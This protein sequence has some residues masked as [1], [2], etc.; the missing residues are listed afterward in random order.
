MNQ[1]RESAKI[2]INVPV[3]VYKLLRV[4]SIMEE[5]SVSDVINDL[6]RIGMAE[7]DK[8]KRSQ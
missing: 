2:H 1:D 8:E 5:K 7:K 4:Q 6:I 3:D